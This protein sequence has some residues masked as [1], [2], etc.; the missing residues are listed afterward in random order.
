MHR[1]EAVP[2][3]AVVDLVGAAGTGSRPRMMNS[4]RPGPH[5]VRSQP[6]DITW[7]RVW[8][9]A[10][11]G[12]ENP[13][14]KRFCGDCGA[15]LSSG[16]PSCGASNPPGK[17]FCGDCGTALGAATGIAPAAV[18]GATPPSASPIPAEPTIAERRLV[19]ILFADLVGFTPFSEERD[20]E[21]VRETLTRYFELATEVI[22][23]YGGTVEKFIG[24]AVMAVWGTPTVREDDAERAV[25]A[26]L[27]LVDAVSA[28]GPRASAPG[29][30]C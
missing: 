27:E 13:A 21:E 17:R 11:C 1:A 24:D 23:R 6:P 22:G 2:T 20:S 8:S 26:A 28:V 16:C 10:S 12:T 15:P 29:R 7:E 18:G 3:T 9:C 5:V 14:D 19:S 30:A 4:L 25:R